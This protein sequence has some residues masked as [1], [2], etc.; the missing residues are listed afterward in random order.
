MI[1]NNEY[2]NTE[3]GRKQAAGHCYSLYD[4]WK[5]KLTSTEMKGISFDKIGFNA[6]KIVEE[7]IDGS[8]FDV[9]ELTAAVGD[10]FF[11]ETFVPKEVLKQLATGWNGTVHDLSHLG[12]NYPNGAYG[13]RE[14]IDY[15]VGY[16][17]DSYWDEMSNSVK[18]KAYIAHDAPKY[19]AWKN[20]MNICRITGNTPNVSMAVTPAVFRYMNIKDLPMGVNIPQKYVRNNKVRALAG[21]IPHAI[22]TCLTG[23]CDDKAGCGIAA[24]ILKDCSSGSCDINDD[25]PPEKEGSDK[26]GEKTPLTKQA[27]FLKMIKEADKK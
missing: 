11:Q 18:M 24:A 8:K 21:G 13:S 1:D 16:N 22:T 19:N 7:E 14:N 17:N 25:E 15:I 10:I 3:E 12:T 23:K 27:K 20:Y 4:S 2:P 6:S 9:V 5:E 26:T